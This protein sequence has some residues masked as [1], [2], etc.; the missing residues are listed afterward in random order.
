MQPLSRASAQV[1]WI[2]NLTRGFTA[3]NHRKQ[4]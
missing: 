1:A 4:L 2:D 3:K